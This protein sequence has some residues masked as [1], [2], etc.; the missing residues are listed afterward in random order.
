MTTLILNGLSSTPFILKNYNRNTTFDLENNTM[1]SIAFFDIE[2]EANTVSQLS[3]LGQTTITNL[4]IKH[5]SDT[6]YNLA[7]LH[8]R[9]AS[10]NENL[11]DGEKININV[12]LRF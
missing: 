4:T 3:S 7:N 10:M 12:S 11:Y 1:N 2:N 5:D 6:I 8:A 9:I